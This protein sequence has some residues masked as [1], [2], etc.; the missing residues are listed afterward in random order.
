MCLALDLGLSLSLSLGMSDIGWLVL[1]DLGLLHFGHWFSHGSWLTHSWRDGPLL[2][3]V[4]HVADGH[5]R[6]GELEVLR[7]VA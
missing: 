1:N 4:V 3:P 2:T 7:L 5:A 6:V